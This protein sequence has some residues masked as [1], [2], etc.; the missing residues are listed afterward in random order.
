MSAS[1]RAVVRVAD[2]RAMVMGSKPREDHVSVCLDAD[3]DAELR[4][5]QSELVQAQQADE[6]SFS[7][8]Q[9][10]GVLRAM[11]QLRE[12]V[13]EQSIILHLRAMPW[14]AALRLEAEHPPREGNKA[15]QAV[16][17]NQETYYP[18]L[19]QRTCYKVTHQDGTELDAADLGA[20]WWEALFTSVNYA[21][22]DNVFAAAFTLNRRDSAAPFLP[23][24]SQT[25]QQRGGDSGQQEPGESHRGGSKAG[26]R[27]RSTRSRSGTR[28]GAPS[29]G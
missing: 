14:T 29:G 5:L 7:G 11:E 27:G 2:I 19:V 3:L 10:R 18:A 4:A 9:A 13:A 1:P 15:D 12:R 17:H 26:N 24:A 20:D 22:F 23:T 28:K 16:G 25:P 21:Q 6:Q 8:G